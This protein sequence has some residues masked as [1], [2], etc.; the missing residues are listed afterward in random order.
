[1]MAD[2]PTAFDALAPLC[3]VSAPLCEVAGMGAL[4][5]PLEL[6]T[7]CTRIGV[8]QARAGD[9][10]RALIAGRSVGVF[11]KATALN[12]H[13]REKSIAA[14]L[15]PLLR[16]AHLYRSRVHRDDD[17]VEVVLTKPPAPSQVSLQLENMLS[18]S[19]RLRDTK[20]LLPSIAEAARM[21]F[22]VMTPYLDEVGAAIVLNL[23]E[24]A[25]VRDRCLILRATPDGQAPPGLAGVRSELH[26][27]GVM[28]LNFRLDRPGYSGNET[29]HAKVVLAD[30]ASAYIGSSNMHKW[31]F[32]YSL[33]LGL[34]VR[35][36]AAARIADIL[37]AVRAVSGR[38]P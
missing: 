2:L 19:W 24:Q 10:E 25:D 38:I 16:G 14:Q 31:S 4:D 5:L 33:E 11:S 34:H 21:S 18:G 26:Q 36:R 6:R 35:G 29:F 7:I 9:V 1:M 20:Q 12:W 13:V 30:D 23:F 17:L 27:L 28:V 15:A 22:T 8:P 3:E 32:E 37:L